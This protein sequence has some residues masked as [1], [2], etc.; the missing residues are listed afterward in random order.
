MDLK[1]LAG[2]YLKS[3]QILVGRIEQLT[4]ELASPGLSLNK[5]ESLIYRISVLE[6]MNRSA[7]STA[8]YLMAYYD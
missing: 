6:K 4:I 8:R 1:T 5:K 3:A 7:R 2:E